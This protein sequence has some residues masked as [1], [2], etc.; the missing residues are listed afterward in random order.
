M[1]LIGNY[2]VLHKT[3]GRFT[4]GASIAQCRSNFGSS[5]SLRNSYSHFGLLAS[6]PSGYAAPYSWSM[7]RAIGAM[8]SFT[9]S[10]LT[11]IPIANMAAGRN[12]EASVNISITVTN[13]QLDQI[14]SFIASSL[15]TI[16]GSA[17]LNAAVQMQASAI[18]AITGTA[19]VGAII[20]SLASS[21]MSI[22]PSAI[23]TALAHMNAEAGGPTP[24][25]PEGLASAVWDTVLSDH[26]ALGSTGK[27]LSDAGGAGNPWSADLASN[28]TAGTFGALV[29]K[30]LTVDKFLRLR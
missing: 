14:V 16:S 3:P 13:A 23:L 2:S 4:S 6:Y 28:N 20:D 9:S 10:N 15:M 7:A 1:A 30:L 8:S 12:L 26:Q 24:L 19:S 18:L 22:T 29:Q 25:S 5:G 17:E 27:A 21:N 11:L